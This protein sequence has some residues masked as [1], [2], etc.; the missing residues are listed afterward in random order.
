MQKVTEF[1]CKWVMNKENIYEFINNVWSSEDNGARR[2]LILLP[3]PQEVV[4]RFS[5]EQLMHMLAFSFVQPARS[6]APSVCGGVLAN[7]AMHASRA[8]T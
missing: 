1:Y 5:H 3:M 7:V 8:L 6:F 4:V 2:R